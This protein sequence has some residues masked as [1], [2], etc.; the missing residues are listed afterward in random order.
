LRRAFENEEFEVHYQPIVDLSDGRI[1]SF[2][3]LVRWQHPERGLLYPNEFIET[4]EETG[5]I[6]PMGMMVMRDACRQTR[7]WNTRFGFD[8]PLSV[9][10]NVSPRQFAQETLVEQVRDVLFETGLN[11]ACLEVEVTEN[12]T[13]KDVDRAVRLLSELSKLGVSISLDDFGT[14]YSSLSYLLRFPIQTLKID[15]SFVSNIKDTKESSAIVQTIIALSHN[16]GKTVVAEGIETVDQMD[17]LR[18]LH[19]D[20]GQGYL[21][22][23]P[24]PAARAT[25]MLASYAM[26]LQEV[27]A[28]EILLAA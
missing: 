20:L 9:C 23:R 13:M 5:L 10:V 26:S 27:Q 7:E 11:P 17:L 14:G 6:V 12:L 22:S 3:A 1:L 18:E 4:A 24:V 2:E 16:L 15:R 8:I 28:R 25:E 21:F 19:C